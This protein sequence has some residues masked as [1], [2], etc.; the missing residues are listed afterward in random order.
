MLLCLFVA[1]Q[2]QFVYRPFTDREKQ[3]CEK[4][5][6]EKSFP[7]QRYNQRYI[8]G[9]RPTDE[10][11][12]QVALGK[13][14]FFA[15]PNTLEILSDKEIT[16][17]TFT[18]FTYKIEKIGKEIYKISFTDD[19]NKVKTQLDQWA[20]KNRH[21]K[22]FNVSGKNIEIPYPSIE[23]VTNAEIMGCPTWNDPYANVN[24][25]ANS[26]GL[27]SYWLDDIW[28]SCNGYNNVPVVGL[29]KVASF[30][31]LVQGN[32]TRY[33]TMDS[34]VNNQNNEFDLI[35]A[36]DTE[37]NSPTIAPD[38][39]GTAT[40]ELG[41]GHINGYYSVGTAPWSQ[42]RAIDDGTD[43][44]GL[45]TAFD[46][47]IDLLNAQIANDTSS[48]QIISLS[49]MNANTAT[50]QAQTALFAQNTGGKGVIL[51]SSGNNLTPG[52]MNPLAEG[53][54]TIAIGA[55]DAQSPTRDLWS[56]SSYGGDLSSARHV[57]AV[58]DGANLGVPDVNW[59]YSQH[60]GTSFS[61]PIVAG[62]VNTYQKFFPNHTFT[63]ITEAFANT[64]YDLQTAGYDAQTG[65]GY[66]QLHKALIYGSSMSM[67]AS[68]NLN[69][70]GSYTFTFTPE[71]LQGSTLQAQVLKYPNGTNVP[72]N[73]VGGNYVYSITVSSANGFV[74]GVNQLTYTVTAPAPNAGCQLSGLTRKITVSNMATLA[75]SEVN[76]KSLKIYP[77]PAKDFLTIDNTGNIEKVEIYSATGQLVQ[78]AKDKKVNVSA[79][80]KGN[81]LV[82]VTTGNVVSSEKFIKE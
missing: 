8:I 35:Y 1:M 55:T 65:Y 4:Q 48:R 47:G 81:Y 24:D 51:V 72:F 79:L 26:T 30:V 14:I 31:Y 61:T 43:P 77:N 67:P 69:N 3:D 41:N 21:I 62:Q 60:N 29:N 82:K 38:N 57:F 6:M 17:K 70:A 71:T 49:I 10:R 76:K 11:V 56:G 7:D 13:N 36:Y 28:W 18:G 40:A 33:N 80:A 39:H 9:K 22:K 19:I 46:A 45:S 20:E 25:C 66:V 37:H 12:V 50:W 64:C 27:E 68:I 75:T 2:A 34:G 63:Q 23:Y 15:D 58:A 5:L 73:I 16:N 52:T 32:V 44:G 42:L 54:N 59:N 78:T 53:V 74:N